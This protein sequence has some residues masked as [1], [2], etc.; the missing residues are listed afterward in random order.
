MERNLSPR[1]TCEIGVLKGTQDCFEDIGYSTPTPTPTN[2]NSEYAPAMWLVLVH[3][4]GILK[5]VFNS[6]NFGNVNL[7]MHVRRFSKN[8]GV[9][10]TMA[11]GTGVVVLKVARDWKFKNLK[12]VY[13]FLS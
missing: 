5:S 3:I 4:V 10:A 13:H 7:Y 9:L 1:Y 6:T 11:E 2:L 8:R 12:I